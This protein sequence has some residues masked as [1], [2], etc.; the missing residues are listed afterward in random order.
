M[1]T[2][3][4]RGRKHEVARFESIEDAVRAYLHNINTFP[5]YKTLRTIR[6]ELRE[7]SRRITGVRLAD[8]LLAYSE[9]RQ[10]YVEEVKSM[11]RQN[12]LE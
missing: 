9:R 6:A 2:A 5:R 11:I 4:E 3:R 7:A 8:G 1:P 12:E 10:A